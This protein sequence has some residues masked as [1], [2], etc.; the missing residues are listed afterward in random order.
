MWVLNLS[1][2]K[3][4]SF[5]FIEYKMCVFWFYR[6]KNVCVLIFFFLSFSFLIGWQLSICICCKPLFSLLYNR[7][8]LCF[9][10]LAL[11]TAVQF[12]PRPFFQ[13]FLLQG[14]LPQTRYAQLYALSKS[15]VY[16]FKFLEVIFLLWPFEKLHHSLFYLSILFLTFF[17][18]TMFQ[19]HL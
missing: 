1:N 13:I 5:D 12:F 8:L 3:C 17:S 14:Y 15:G 6:T 9:W 18:S 4:V 7:Q 19:M 11:S 2:I 10:Q 16:F